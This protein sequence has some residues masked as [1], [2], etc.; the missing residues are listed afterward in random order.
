MCRAWRDDAKDRQMASDRMSVQQA[1][2]GRAELAAVLAGQGPALAVCFLFSAFVNLLFLTS[3]LYMLQVYDRV[4]AARS[5]ATL[6]ALSLLVAFLFL[7]LGVLDHA[8]GRIL[9]RVGARFRT[10]LDR[11]VHAAALQRQIAAPGDPAAQMA[12]QDLDAI[13]RFWASPAL[14][15]LLD[16]PWTPIFLGALFLFHPL[17]GWLAIGGGA[18]LVAATLLSQHRTEAPLRALAEARVGSARERHAQQTGAEAIHA[19]GMLGPAQDRA[20]FWRTQGLQA[21]LAA[22]D[23][24][25]GWASLS[26]S[27]RLFLQ[28]AMLGAA[29]WLVLRDALSPGAM[30]AASVLLGRALAPVEQAVAHWPAVIEARQARDR[31]AGLLSRAPTPAPVMALP[32]PQARLEVSGLAVAPPQGGRVLLRGVGFSLGPGQALGVIGPSGAGKTALARALTGIWPPLAGQV[33]LDGATLC[34]YPPG[35]IGAAIG[36]LPQQVGLFDGTVAE[37]IARL[38]SAAPPERVIAAARAAAAHEMILRLPGGYGCRLT[39]ASPGL[40]GGQMQR[41]A[42]ARALYG[43]P[44]LLI[45]DEPNAHLD[46]DG[47]AAL[48]QAIRAAK[49]S[50][51]AVILM[52]HRPSALQDCDQLMVLRD[53]AVAAFGPRD[54]VLRD[55]VRNAGDIARSIGLGATG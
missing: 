23:R 2:P 33:R 26:R 11:R 45:L 27:F 7:I 44:T 53:G 42:L 5:E 34:Q 43:D 32:R 36:Y 55:Q 24:A 38:E 3:P 51:A 12:E 19:L 13:A 4:L 17:L 31:L 15:A 14:V 48:N 40:S 21:W 46:S 25:G 47:A 16:A 6:V 28:S 50:G 52:A 54:Q 35:V 22:A 1:R 30:V 20:I 29:A 8:R 49:G 39:A 41:I 10:G 18:G 9:V 37:N